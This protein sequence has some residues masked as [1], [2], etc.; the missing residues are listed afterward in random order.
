MSYICE[1]N[2]D[3]NQH[4]NNESA[5]EEMRIYMVTDRKHQY[6]LH[7][8]CPSLQSTKGKKVLVITEDC[9]LIEKNIKE[10]K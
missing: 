2:G 4:I 1:C 3:C 8:D 9:V 7:P 5:W 6:I 10:D